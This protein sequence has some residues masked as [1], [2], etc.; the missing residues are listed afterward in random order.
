M[1]QNLKLIPSLALFYPE[2]KTGESFN[3]LSLFE[4]GK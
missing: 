1:K 4:T 3:L 2:D